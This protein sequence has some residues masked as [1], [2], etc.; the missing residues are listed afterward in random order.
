MD[1]E[2]PLHSAAKLNEYK[3]REFRE[4]L[5]DQGMTLAIVKCNEIKFLNLSF[6]F[7]K[8]CR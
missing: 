5:V 4:Y 6:T 7:I 3:E 2:A 8:K 1:K